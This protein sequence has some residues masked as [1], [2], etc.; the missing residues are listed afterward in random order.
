MT[1]QQ[2][3]QGRSVEMTSMDLDVPIIQFVNVCKRYGEVDALVDLSFEIEKN[4]FMFITGPSGAG[5]STLIKLLYFGERISS[6]SAIVDGVNLARISP[7]QI[8]MLRRRMGVI[9]QDFKLIP[10]KTVFKNIALVLEA[11]GVGSLSV[12]REQVLSVLKTVGLENRWAS[13]PPALSGGEQQRVAVAR[14]MVGKPNI[15]LADEPTAS[16]D[17]DSAD[18]IF[19][20]LTQMHARGTT[21]I[22]TTHDKD[23]LKRGDSNIIY[24]KSGRIE[25]GAT[26]SG[27]RMR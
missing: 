10:S 14:A 1:P 13:Y 19:S 18:R 25:G 6:G 21:V 2:R 23:L 7:K 9:F 12:I 27:G 15:I 5:K 20:L 3:Q 8:P 4:D 24:L 17:P 26:T 11:A 16:L 22:I